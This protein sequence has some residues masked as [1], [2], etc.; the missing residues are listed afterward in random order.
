MSFAGW[1]IVAL[2]VLVAVYLTPALITK[3]Q[4]LVETPVEDRFSDRITIVKPANCGLSVRGEPQRQQ[5]AILR[6]LTEQ[7]REPRPV[8][9]V[10]ARDIE[11]EVAKEGGRD[12]RDNTEETRSVIRRGVPSTSRQLAKLRAA[13][14]ARIARENAA[15]QRRFVLA[16]ISLTLLVAFGIAA[17]FS[18]LSP[19]WLLA[20][21][22]LMSG[23]IASGRIAYQRSV[24]AAEYETLM[25]RKLRGE[26]VREVPQFRPLPST[27]TEAIE[28][29]VEINEA[30][31]AEDASHEVSPIDEATEEA[32]TSE[33]TPQPIPQPLYA[34]DAT[35][36]RTVAEDPEEAED[37]VDEI[38]AEIWN[39]VRPVAPSA[40]PADAV[41]SEEAASQAPV[42]FNLEEILDHR[43]AQ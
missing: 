26:K 4:R 5:P 40:T 16:G 13:R 2:A 20:P 12:M 7:P 42:A 18:A 36:R 29:S 30:E 10:D 33:W 39:P 19:W 3:R 17:W 23:V 43:R 6:Q 31:V 28:P 37:E 38:S 11:I 35:I 22:A 24:A 27:E 25:L 32:A 14:A 15:G 21:V 34:T 8:I 41:S 1:I 9:R